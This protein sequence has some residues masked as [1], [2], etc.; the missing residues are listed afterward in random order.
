MLERIT[1][2]LLTEVD[3]PIF[4]ICNALQWYC[5][6][7]TVHSEYFSDVTVKHIL[8]GLPKINLSWIKIKF[9]ENGRWRKEILLLLAE[10]RQ[11]M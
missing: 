3:H 1:K 2:K 5:V 9:W 10:G 4:K 8:Y 7:G 6:V 11:G